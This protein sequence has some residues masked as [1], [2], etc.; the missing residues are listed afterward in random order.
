MKFFNDDIGAWDT[1][2]VVDMDHMF[3]ENTHFN[4]DISDWKTSKVKDMGY[5]T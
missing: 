2:N 1:S 3:F 5:M 4:Q